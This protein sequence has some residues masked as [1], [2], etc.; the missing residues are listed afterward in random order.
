[1]RKLLALKRSLGKGSL[2]SV[3]GHYERTGTELSKAFLNILSEQGVDVSGQLTIDQLGGHDEFHTWGRNSTELFFEGWLDDINFNSEGARVLDAGCGL[4]GVSR[5]VAS[6]YNCH[7]VGVDLTP[8]FVAAAKELSV[9]TGLD[10]L[11]EFMVASVTD[12]PALE[13][14]SFEAAYTIHVGMN[15]QDKLGFYREVFRLLKA[16]SPF[17]IFD[18]VQVPENPELLLPVPWASHPDENHLILPSEYEEIMRSVGFSISSSEDVS[19]IIRAG[20]E[21]GWKKPVLPGLIFGDKW[22]HIEK[23]MQQNISEGRYKLHK[24]VGLKPASSL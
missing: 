15:I 19:W 7:V 8:R 11:T 12:L 4:G 20:M 21:L 23:A 6:R 10:L 1:M 2:S 18:C 13:D 22:P 14:A 24:L 3:V 9:K 16:G 5:Y 17:G